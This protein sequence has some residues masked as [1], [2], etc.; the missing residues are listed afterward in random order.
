MK[1]FQLPK[2]AEKQMCVSESLSFLSGLLYFL[3]QSVCVL[4]AAIMRRIR[5]C[6]GGKVQLVTANVE[7]EERGLFSTF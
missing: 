1:A 2:M 4:T 7:N 5:D 6:T 3:Y